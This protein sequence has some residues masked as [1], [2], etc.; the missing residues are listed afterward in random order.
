MLT[1]RKGGEIRT[2]DLHI[3]KPISQPTELPIRN[4]KYQ[5]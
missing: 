2:S 4:N 5:N 1:Q 3:I